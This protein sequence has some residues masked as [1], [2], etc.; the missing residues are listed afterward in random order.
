M[1]NREIVEVNKR[2]SIW[3]EKIVVVI[4]DFVIVEVE[5]VDLF[6]YEFLK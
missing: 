6:D 3:K 1:K 5:L 2:E 4:R